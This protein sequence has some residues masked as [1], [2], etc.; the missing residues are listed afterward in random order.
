NSWA[1]GYISTLASTGITNGDG[2]GS[3]GSD[4]LL[5]ID[6]LKVFIKRIQQ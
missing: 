1:N 3:F 5:K 4:E 2:E 6:Q